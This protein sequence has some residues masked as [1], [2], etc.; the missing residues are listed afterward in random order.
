MPMIGS[1]P[2]QALFVYVHFVMGCRP[3]GIPW[4]AHTTAPS[5][6]PGPGA[7]LPPK[8]STRLLWLFLF[9]LG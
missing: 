7:K 3:P 2:S 1:P 4:Q 8:L 5:F 9:R 6:T